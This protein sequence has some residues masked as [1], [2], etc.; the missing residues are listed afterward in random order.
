MEKSTS[1]GS[2]LGG[3]MYR[4]HETATPYDRVVGAVVWSDKRPG[5]AVIV[6]ETKT[7]LKVLAEAENLTLSRLVAHCGELHEKFNVDTWYGDPG[8]AKLA[9]ALAEY[10]KTRHAQGKATINLVPAPHVDATNPLAFCVKTIEEHV[11]R[12]DMGGAGGVTEAVR[13]KVWQ[14]RVHQ[15]VEEF[16]RVA[17]LG[18]AVSAIERYPL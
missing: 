1:V 15:G 14:D 3:A 4:S 17:A 9:G 2:S 12:L 10:N 7:S 16:P 8:N 13:E 18:Y 6:G 11:A 5:F